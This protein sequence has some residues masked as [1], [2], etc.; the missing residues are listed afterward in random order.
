MADQTMVSFRYL[1]S[2]RDSVRGVYKNKLLVTNYV[3]TVKKLE[4]LRK[5]D[6]INNEVCRAFRNIYV[7]AKL[8]SSLTIACQTLCLLFKLSHKMTP[9]TNQTIHRG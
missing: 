9:E 1:I 2:D 5:T 3:R 6:K 7:R 4:F 8:L